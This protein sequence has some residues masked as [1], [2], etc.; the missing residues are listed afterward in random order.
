MHEIVF[1]FGA[2][3]T[4]GITGVVGVATVD[5]SVDLGL[6]HPHHAGRPRNGLGQLQRGIGDLGVEGF[7]QTAAI[8]LWPQWGV[9]QGLGGVG[10]GDDRIAILGGQIAADGVGFNL[11]HRQQPD[12]VFALVEVGDLPGTV[13]IGPI[14]RGGA[15]A[16]MLRVLRLYLEFDVD[17]AGVTLRVNLQ[18][19]CIA[20]GCA[21]GVGR[22][23][24]LVRHAVVVVVGIPHIGRAVAIGVALGHAGI[25]QILGILQT[26]GDAIIVGIRVEWVG[27][28]CLA[29]AGEAIDLDGIADP[30]LVGVDKARV[31]AQTGFLLIGKAL[32]VG[33]DPRRA[34]AALGHWVGLGECG[35]IRLARA[36]GCE[37]SETLAQQLVGAGLRGR[38]FWG[39]GKTQGLG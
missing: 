24:E 39:G 23:V 35:E 19:Q 16:Q 28:P 21:H 5:V 8:G 11:Q 3:P 27:C 31:G 15:V 14:Q 29:A 20:I 33:I 1:G 18:L 25:N 4:C 6:H 37:T 13:V 30:V 9:D 32:L 2:T 12:I 17:R 26:I 22:E 34:L 36:I 38:G 7:V 10:A